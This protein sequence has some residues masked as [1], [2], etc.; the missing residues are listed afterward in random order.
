MKSKKIFFSFAF[1]IIL[2]FFVFILSLILGSKNINIISLFCDN[3][4]LMDVE[5]NILLKI[6]LSRSILACISGFS[7]A[8][9]GCICQVFFRNS[10]AEPG[11]M[12]LSS[13]ATLGAVLTVSLTTFSGFS[14]SSTNIGA[15]LGALIAGLLV[16]FISN[17]I[18]SKNSSI[19]LLL[20][21]TALGTLYSAFTSIILAT[22][23]NKLQSMY[24]WMLG[25][26]SG[27]GW[28]EIKF[29][30]IPFVLSIL[31]MM[32]LSSK[33][34]LLVGGEI[35]AM[36][37]GL[38]VN[39]IRIFVIIISSLACS[40]SVCAGGTIG[41]VGLI[42]PHICRKIIGVKLTVLL[43]YS[44]IMGAV[45]M[46]V[47]DIISR[48]VIAPGEIPVGTITSLLGVPFFISL[49]LSKRND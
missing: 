30:I 23:G 26:F 39:L 13:G 49:L 5:K 22:D 9:A 34:D 21:G 41:F 29:L 28:I 15:F 2:F 4:D 36:S 42:A 43:P 16:V 46:L 44:M 25:S 3:N 45:I 17:S 35:S 33:L 37:L 6:R 1:L 18:N 27:R 10:L 48:T 12:G 8:G 11:I 32:M 24:M 40:V 47:S 19:V 14:N 7:L 31:F 20:T 38:N